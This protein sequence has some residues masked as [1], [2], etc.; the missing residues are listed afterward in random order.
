MDV[1]EFKG[2]PVYMMSSRRTYIIRPCFKTNK[3]TKRK[4]KV[5]NGMT[6]PEV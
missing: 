6:S 1:C 5:W 3:K 2:N 4:Q